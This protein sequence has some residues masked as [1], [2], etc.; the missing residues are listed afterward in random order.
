[1]FSTSI[2]NAAG[3]EPPFADSAL[4]TAFFDFDKTLICRNS[5]NLWL[6]YELRD[7]HI[8]KRQLVRAMGWLLRYRFGSSDLHH[9]FAESIAT[10]KG[11]SEDD[12]RQR[13]A[14]FYQTWLR[15]LYRPGALQAIAHHRRLGHRVVLLTTAS[16]YLAQPVA[17]HLGLDAYICTHLEVG[18][19]GRFT[20]RPIEPLCFGAG[21]RALAQEYASA[22]GISLRHC[23]FYTDSASDI[24]ALS[25]VGSPVAVHP[26]P[27]LRRHAKRCGWP[28]VDWGVP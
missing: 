18:P 16:P 13:T 24:P 27:R 5:A 26:D 3:N 14:L 25:A 6:R 21:K 22:H 28:I 1:M 2:S 9:A 8:T 12:L 15:D 10:L 4:H 23:A 11:T 7:G 17:H 19:G 20:G